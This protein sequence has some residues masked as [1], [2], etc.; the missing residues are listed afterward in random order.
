[1]TV[2]SSLASSPHEQPTVT[3][4]PPK[5]HVEQ[6]SQKKSNEKL[7]NTAV[8]KESRMDSST[9]KVVARSRHSKTGSEQLFAATS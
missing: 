4:N 3:D 7:V 1:M 6:R 8:T 9:E 5:I 2:T